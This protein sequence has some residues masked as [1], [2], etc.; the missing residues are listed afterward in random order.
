MA[1]ADEPRDLVVACRRLLDRQPATGPLWW[2]AGH[3]LTAPDARHGIRR[4]LE[5]LDRDPTPGFVAEVLAHTPDA[6]MI[7]AWSAGP[8]QALVAPE[9]GRPAPNAPRWLVTGTGCELPSQIWDALLRRRERLSHPLGVFVALASLDGVVGPRGPTV[10]ARVESG[11]GFP[12]APEILAP[13][14]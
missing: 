10:P 13:S 4:A 14:L 3:A 1:C 12:I 7:P 5:D 6:V 9:P 8:D 2:L 11:P